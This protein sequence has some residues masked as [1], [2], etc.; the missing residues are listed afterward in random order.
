MKF[1]K[2]IICIIFCCLFVFLS[3][4]KNQPEKSRE[5]QIVLQQEA[6]DKAYEEAQALAEKEAAEK[7]AAEREAAAKVAAEKKAAGKSGGRKEGC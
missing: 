6:V 1:K 4:E 7:E 2:D 3:C 5:S